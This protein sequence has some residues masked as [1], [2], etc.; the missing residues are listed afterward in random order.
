MENRNIDYEESEV[1]K[2]RDSSGN[3]V[4]AHSLQQHSR[5]VPGPSKH[6]APALFNVISILVFFCIL[7]V[8]V[9]FGVFGILQAR[10]HNRLCWSHKYQP[11]PMYRYLQNGND[12][13][14]QMSVDSDEDVEEENDYSA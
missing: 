13:L 12:K 3:S 10:S 7:S 6:E 1:N 8:S 14:I 2:L 5:G 9:F 11:I 4:V